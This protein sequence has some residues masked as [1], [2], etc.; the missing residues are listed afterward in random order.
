MHTA[1][2]PAVAVCPSASCRLWCPRNDYNLTR[3]IPQRECTKAAALASCGAPG[4]YQ[5]DERHL[6]CDVPEVAI[7]REELKLVTNTKLSD[8][9]VDRAH[10]NAFSP[11]QVPQF[12]CFDMILHVGC[13]ERKNRKMPHDLIAGPGTLEPLQKFLEDQPC[14]EDGVTHLERPCEERDLGS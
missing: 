4:S 11:A 3:T 10:L 5:E 7:T 12:G 2:V 9:S 6:L 14:G 13:D 8:E 1:V